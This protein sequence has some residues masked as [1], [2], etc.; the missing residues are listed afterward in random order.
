MNYLSSKHPDAFLDYPGKLIKPE[1]LKDF[2]ECPLCLG[3]GGWNLK[4][5]AYRL[6]VENTQENRHKYSHFR[7]SCSQCNGWGY[8]SV[9]NTK[10]IHTWIRVSNDGKCLSTWACEH[11]NVKQQIDSSD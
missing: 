6:Y 7:C 10:C 11:C 9:L 3:F 1:T 8:V 2:V 5:N 4:L